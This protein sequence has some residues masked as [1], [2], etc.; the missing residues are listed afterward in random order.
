[1]QI[2]FKNS[3]ASGYDT[4]VYVSRGQFRSKYSAIG[5]NKT[6]YFNT[7][8]DPTDFRDGDLLLDLFSQY[9]KPLPNSPLIGFG[10]INGAPNYDYFGKPRASGNDLGA[11]QV[12]N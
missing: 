8:F 10:D 4:A 11:I 3:F 7:T 12:S 6:N 2:T 1:M 5:G 9:V